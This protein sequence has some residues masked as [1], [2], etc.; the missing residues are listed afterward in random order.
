MVVVKK[1]ATKTRKGIN[2]F[3]RP[4]MAQERTARDAG[5]DHRRIASTFCG[6]VLG[7]GE[8]V[9]HRPFERGFSASESPP[10]VG[11]HTHQPARSGPRGGIC[12]STGVWKD[13]GTA[14]KYVCNNATSTRQCQFSR[15]SARCNLR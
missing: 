9:E 3:T 13:S 7:K 15:P 1:P 2:P 4:R 8:D 11:R 5:S 12:D 6:K 14:C 10:V